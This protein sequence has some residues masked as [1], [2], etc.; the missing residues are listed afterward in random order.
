VQ[1]EN[2]ALLGYYAARNGNFLPTVRDNLSV[3]S[4]GFKNQSAVLCYFAA[5]ACNHA[6]CTPVVRLYI[7]ATHLW[8]YRTKPFLV[9]RAVTW[10]RRLS[11]TSQRRLGV[12]FQVSPSRI[13]CGRSGTGTGFPSATLV[14]PWWTV[15]TNTQTF[16]HSSTIDDIIL[17]NDSI[18]K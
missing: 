8:F 5:Q 13:C 14:F 15:R 4:S 16:T 1:T 3:S 12:L 17:A 11:L 18:V 6:K 7:W 10:L 2:C 9:S